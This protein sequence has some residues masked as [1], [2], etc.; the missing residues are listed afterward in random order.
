MPG[1]R[2][3]DAA[4][5]HSFGLELDGVRVSMLTEVTGLGWERDVIEVRQ[6]GDPDAP[7]RRLPGRLKPG[8]VTVT[9]GLS[10]DVAFEIPHPGARGCCSGVPRPDGRG[11]AGAYHRDLALKRAAPACGPAALATSP[12]VLTLVPRDSSGSAPPRA[13]GA[14]RACR[15]PRRRG[16]TGS[17]RPAPRRRSTRRSRCS[18]RSSRAPTT[19][20]ASSPR[21]TQ[22]AASVRSSSWP[23]PEPRCAGVT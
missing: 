21:S 22:I 1:R 14:R 4:V 18:A 7:T 6:G 5:G 9:R 8:E 17:T 16:G 23:S 13:A 11:A 2:E 20:A 3:P 19:R 15:G 10:T 12:R